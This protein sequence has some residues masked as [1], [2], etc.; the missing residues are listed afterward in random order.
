MRSIFAHIP[1][2]WLMFIVVSSPAI[3][4]PIS[5]PSYI[6]SYVPQ[7]TAMGSGRLTYLLWE[8][9]DARLFTPRG[10]W[11][12]TP[13][14]AL[15]LH[16]LM[17]LDG[18]KIAERSVDEMRGQG[19]ADKSKLDIWQQEMTRIFPNV[20]KGDTITGIF[21]AEGTTLFYLNQK[22][23]GKVADPSFGEYFFGIWLNDKTSE[24]KLR[25]QLLSL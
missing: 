10:T 15:E 12:N 6:L 22:L 3:A 9:Y 2:L 11:K 20:K 14:Y 23:I 13:P 25:K 17:S 1:L 24:P 4:D 7:A 21:D 18:K 8:V 5:P 19:F 16:Y